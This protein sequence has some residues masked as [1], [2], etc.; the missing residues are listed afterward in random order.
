MCTFIT[1]TFSAKDLEVAT[2][3]LSQSPLYLVLYEKN[4]MRQEEYMTADQASWAL[5][6]DHSTRILLGKVIELRGHR[7]VQR[8]ITIE[9][10]KKIA[11]MALGN[12]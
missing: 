11:N 5:D 1:S 3:H 7:L 10:R 6:P 4:G 9:E 8:D 2:R 12:G